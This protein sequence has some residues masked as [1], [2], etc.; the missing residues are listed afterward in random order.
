MLPRVTSPG[1]HKPNSHHITETI[2]SMALE[3]QS[4]SQLILRGCMTVNKMPIYIAHLN[5]NLDTK[6]KSGKSDITFDSKDLRFTFVLIDTFH[7]THMSLL[8]NLKCMIDISHG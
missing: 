3:H 6:Y 1:S 5:P 4:I 2:A 8:A 7:I